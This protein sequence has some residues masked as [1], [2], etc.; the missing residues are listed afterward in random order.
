MLTQAAAARELRVTKQRVAVLVKLGQLGIISWQG[1]KYVTV[2]SLER[3]MALPP[4]RHPNQTGIR[5]PRAPRTTAT[6]AYMQTGAPNGSS[7]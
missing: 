5:R 2:E 3:Y 7:Q 1:R 6:T 4:K